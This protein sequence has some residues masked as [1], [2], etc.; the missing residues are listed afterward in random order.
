MSYTPKWRQQ[1]RERNM[2]GV[3]HS[4]LTAMHFVRALI[5]SENGNAITIVIP[6]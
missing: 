3:A 1:E 2:E 4:S 6:A 5:H